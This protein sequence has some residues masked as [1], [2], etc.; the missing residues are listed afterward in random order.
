M[1]RVGRSA[2]RM[3]VRL[4]LGWSDPWLVGCAGVWVVGSLRAGV[5]RRGWPM[6]LRRVVHA[7]QAAGLG[8]ARVREASAGDL[9]RR[10]LEE[11]R[12][13]VSE[14]C[15]AWRESV[16]FGGMSWW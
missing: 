12:R 11:C 1:R 13:G 6:D 2:E 9:S 15:D 5:G 3:S 8:D 16:R 10:H 14:R 4:Q 7:R